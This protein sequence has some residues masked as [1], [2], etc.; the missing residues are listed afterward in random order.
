MVDEDEPA[1]DS[2]D[3]RND[4]WMKSNYLELIQDYPNRWIAVLDQKVICSGNRRAAV[5]TE[6]KGL[7][8]GREF[9]LYFIEPSG[10]L[11]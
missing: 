3:V 11:P 6:A 2:E 4:E 8:G 7:A 10:I 9:S 1:E 5:E